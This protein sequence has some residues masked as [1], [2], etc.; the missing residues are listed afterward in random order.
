MLVSS[1]NLNFC[2]AASRLFNKSALVYA[3]S[4]AVCSVKQDDGSKILKSVL[5]VH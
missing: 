5:S 4:Y 1:D 3:L 2:N